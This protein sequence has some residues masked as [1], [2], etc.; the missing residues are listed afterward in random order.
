MVSKKA[1]FETTTSYTISSST[2]TKTSTTPI[3]ISTS[4][5]NR[6]VNFINEST[7]DLYIPIA[8]SVENKSLEKKGFKM[9]LM[10][11]KGY[12]EHKVFKPKN[13]V[14]SDSQIG[15]IIAC[16]AGV[17]I[18]ALILILFL[19]CYKRYRYGNALQKNDI[20]VK[21]SQAKENKIKNSQQINDEF[22]VN[23]KQSYFSEIATSMYVLGVT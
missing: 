20:E 21:K 4:K 1:K 19:L 8:E 11:Q 9:D 22:V 12:L 2:L 13:K 7:T 17:F 3:V 18:L 23:Q 5:L 14:L 10:N 6:H 15:I 16:T